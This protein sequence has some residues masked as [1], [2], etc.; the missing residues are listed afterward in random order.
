MRNDHSAPGA[1]R[2]GAVTLVR[3]LHPLDWLAGGLL[4]L[5]LAA[6]AT[7]L[8]PAGAAADQMRR[9]GPL[10][11]FLATVIVLAELAG[12]AQVFDVVAAWVA[13]AG[14][15]RYPL[16]FGLC[17]V[18]ASLT[19][20]TLNLDTTAVLLT[21]VMLALG[22]RVGIAA[23][24]LAMTT[25]WLANTASLL[26]PVS[27]LTNLLAADRVALSPAGLAGVMWLPQLAAIGVTAGCLWVFYWRRGRRGA[28]RYT[29]PALPVPGDPVLL[30]I[31]A[32]ACVGFLLAILLLDVPLWSA[33]LVAMVVVVAAY[34]VRRREELRLSLVPWR[35][36]VLVPGMFLVVETVGAHGLHE[37]LV[38]A[39]G[40]DDGFAG[41]LRSAGV[42][43]GLS[44]VLN[45][46]PAYVAGEAVIPADN[47]H[48]LLALLIG[49]NAGSVV[50]PW[51]SLATLL[52]FERCRWQGTRIDVRR[53]VLT[54]LVLSVTAVSAATC[55]LA[56]VT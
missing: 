29:P 42:G 54:G 12:R 51:G 18:F 22:T 6:A 41:M 36:L 48:Q 20:I 3:R 7:G 44:N 32:V 24:P 52:W 2:S 15:G 5:G 11:A 50:T 9:I 28:D 30:R 53:F 43:A 35:L 47:H 19:T 21:P 27:N 1:V 39:L 55:A 23:L 4:V 8:L 34:A 31:C 56:L 33:S 45:N 40:S 37:L 49:V 17:V 13:R 25:V 10:L 46:L 16:L 14:R 26:L 38:R